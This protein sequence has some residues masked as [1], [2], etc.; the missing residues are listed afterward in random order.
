MQ[1]Y[2]GEQGFDE[3]AVEDIVQRYTDLRLKECMLN[4]EFAQKARSNNGHYYLKMLKEQ[5]TEELNIAEA[6]KPSDLSFDEDFQRIVNLQHIEVDIQGRYNTQDVSGLQSVGLGSLAGEA[7]DNSP[8]D[9]LLQDYFLQKRG[10]YKATNE[11]LDT[12]N[13]QFGSAAIAYG[14]DHKFK[15]KDKL[16]NQG[17]NLYPFEGE[18]GMAYAHLVQS[19]DHQENPRVFA[20]DYNDMLNLDIATQQA[21]NQGKSGLS[22]ALKQAIDHDSSIP[23]YFN[24]FDVRKPTKLYVEDKLDQ[25]L[26]E[27]F[28]VRRRVE[29]TLSRN[30]LLAYDR[31]LA[32]HLTKDALIPRLK[33]RVE[34]QRNE[35]V[36]VKQMTEMGKEGQINEELHYKKS[37]NNQSAFNRDVKNE[38]ALY[39]FLAY[40]GMIEKRRREDLNKTRKDEN[41]AFNLA[42]FSEYYKAEL[43]KDAKREPRPVNPADYQP[44][45]GKVDADQAA[46]GFMTTAQREQ[47]FKDEYELYKENKSK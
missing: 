35:L 8:L 7:K 34:L 38:D 29:K 20:G 24:M 41:I 42:A 33:E 4:E 1:A 45:R 5:I 18:A 19:I 46:E 31:V 43:I 22:S 27:I 37:V 21:L 14:D 32:Q 6:V 10:Q 28:E 25:I 39:K 17:K 16:A 3:A 26:R 12:L 23:E 44:S 11:L 13:E 2:A 15:T 9:K 36:Q 47:N 40:T 30:E